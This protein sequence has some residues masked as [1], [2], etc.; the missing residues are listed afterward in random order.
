[1]DRILE[2]LA[3][4]IRIEMLKQL[5]K[6]DMNYTELIRS[7]GMNPQ[8]DAGKFSY[9]LKKLLYSKL[10]RINEKTKLYELS[11]VGKTMLEVI[12]HAKRKLAGSDLL[13]V[14]RSECSIE[15]FDKNKI[16]NALIKE[17]GMPAK[18]AHKVAS[19][20]E[21][22]LLDLKIEY[23][24]APLIRELVNSVLIDQ[25]LEKYRHKLTRVGMPIYDVTQMIKNASK[26]GGANSVIKVAA[27]SV[28]KEY[29]LLNVLPRNVA[30][31][32]LSGAI[33]ICFLESWVTSVYGK[34]YD[35]N[36]L[37]KT[38]GSDICEA[39]LLGII[40][41]MFT[42][43]KEF[44]L[45][46]LSNIVANKKLS[47]QLASTLIKVL[48]LNTFEERKFVFNVAENSEYTEDFVEVF[49]KHQ[50]DYVSI[51]ACKDLI[52]KILGRY[53]S[54]EGPELIF[55]KDSKSEI[56]A[57]DGYKLS[58]VDS[59]NV[60]SFLCGVAAVNVPRL[61]LQSAGNEEEFIE[62]VRRTIQ[63]IITAFMKK[64]SLVNVLYGNTN[65]KHHF[66]ISPCGMFEA[67]KCLTGEYPTHESSDILLNVV[68]EMVKLVSKSS[69]KD[70]QIGVANVCSP[71][72]SKR[73]T[74]SDIER[75]GFKTI[76]N[77]SPYH[78]TSNFTYSTTIVPYDIKMSQ[79]DRLQLETKVAKVLNGGYIV[80]LFKPSKD[81]EFREIVELAE[82]YLKAG[83][84][85][86]K[87]I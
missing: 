38:E 62:S 13:I 15:P 72:S 23:L 54:K 37:N 26:Q 44:L 5:S 11:H 75:F 48:S 7:V 34:V 59:E 78:T 70:F 86:L 67:I 76:S 84:D 21:E 40:K 32:Y 28:L 49:D 24:S 36:I 56:L 12:E 51:V 35:A 79:E 19:S 42:V 4:P 82:E 53:I 55:T 61:A 39:L 29:V 1:M 71:Q 81:K 80:M 57:S 73:M 31:A 85:S 6:H 65:I 45:Y 60:E 50:K 46:N 27:N 87:F 18:L 14:R 43:E 64:M 8:K 17:A 58:V 33:D 9:H 16:V 52:E 66:I 63:L 2:A 77:I 83:C 3:S 10:I 47:R 30:D 22:K 68:K 20:V 69:K 74:K 25:G 41:D